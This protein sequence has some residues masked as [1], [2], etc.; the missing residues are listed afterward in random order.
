VEHYSIRVNNDCLTIDDEQLFGSLRQ[1]VEHYQREA[2]GLC[3]RLLVPLENRANLRCEVEMEDFGKFG[4]TILKEKVVVHSLLDESEG[5]LTES[6]KGE[7][8][9]KNVGIKRLKDD[10]KGLEDFLA[11]AA[12]MTSLSHPNLVELVGVS[13]D[14]RPVCMVTEFMELGSLRIYLLT[15]PMPKDTL[16]NIACDICRGMACLEQKRLVHRHLTATNIL[17]SGEKVAKVSNF[18]LTRELDYDLGDREFPACWAPPEVLEAKVFSNKSDVWSFGVLL[19]EIYS[20]GEFPYPG[21]R[22]QEAVLYVS[23]GG[24]MAPPE[25]C[26]S[27]MQGI[28][29]ACWAENPQ[30]RPT[31]SELVKIL[32]TLKPSTNTLPVISQETKLLSPGPR[33]RSRSSSPGYSKQPSVE[34][35]SLRRRPAQRKKELATSPETVHIDGKIVSHKIPVKLY[36]APYVIVGV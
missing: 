29:K 28:M 2:D 11:E 24:R 10:F 35:R 9:G 33:V 21:K 34:G 3:T 26:P 5:L 12:I 8:M 17:L 23:Q 7:Y 30:R 4:W 22:N 14:A 32:K 27:A 15:R 6:F 16:V 19:W 20:Y 1:L 31:F 13:V 36:K 18:R 25:G